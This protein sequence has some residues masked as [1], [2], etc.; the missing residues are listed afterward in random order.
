M[1]RSMLLHLF[2]THTICIHTH[3][4]MHIHMC[5]YVC[6]YMNICSTYIHTLHRLTFILLFHPTL[7]SV[8]YFNCQSLRHKNSENW[9]TALASICALLSTFPLLLPPTNSPAAAVW[10]EKL[11]ASLLCG[12]VGRY[13]FVCMGMRMYVYVCIC[14]CMCMCVCVCACVCVCQCVPLGFCV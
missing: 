5:T 10:A 3:T 14:V 7:Q 12:Y 2:Y 1:F 11:P 13:V 4:C 6:T 9:Q 8:L